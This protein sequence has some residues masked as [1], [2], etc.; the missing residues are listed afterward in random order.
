MLIKLDLKNTGT[1]YMC[2]VANV[3][4]YT[5]LQKSMKYVVFFNFHDLNFHGMNINFLFPFGSGTRLS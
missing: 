3:Y 4:L 2:V 1:I 5:F